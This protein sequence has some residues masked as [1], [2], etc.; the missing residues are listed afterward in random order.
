MDTTERD[1]II[2]RLLSEGKSLGE[3]QKILEQD[4]D[5]KMTYMDLRL[6]S[7]ALQVDWTKSDKTPDKPAPDGIPDL[8]AEPEPEAGATKISISKLVRPGALFSGDVTFASG[9]TAEWSVDR[10][11]QLALNPA[12]GSSRPT[13]EDLEDFQIELQRELQ[14]KMGGV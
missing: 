9:A 11:G 14:K 2:A 5:C 1:Q 8:G 13:Q 7:S 3:V 4:H 10:M 6:I 12:E